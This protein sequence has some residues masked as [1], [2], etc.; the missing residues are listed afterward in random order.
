MLDKTLVSNQF[1]QLQDMIH[2][3][4]LEKKLEDKMSDLKNK[5]DNF[6]IKL[7]T[8]GSFSAG[9]SALLNH[10]IG[11]DLLV[12]EQTPETAI[13]TEL[14]F[15]PIEH[16]N[17]VDTNHF[18]K[19]VEKEQLKNANP[20]E[21]L[22][23][24]YA[25][26]NRY[27]APFTD[28][29]FVDMPGFNSN[30]EQHNKAILQYIG[31]GNAYLLVIDCEDGGIKASALE[32]IEEIRQYQHNLIIVLTKSDKKSP[33]QI[34]QIRQNVVN[35]A[36][37]LFDAEVPVITY[38]KFDDSARERL[39][40]AIRTLPIQSI[41]EQTTV[42]ILEELYSYVQMALQQSMKAATLDIHELEQEM[43]KRKKVKKELEEK[44]MSERTKLTNRMRV[45]VLPGIIE[46]VESALYANSTDLAKAAISGERAFS[47]RVNALLR[48]VLLENTKKF[49]E[50]SYEQFLR[51]IDFHTLLA[52]QTEEMVQGLQEKIRQVTELLTHANKKSDDLNKT[53]KAI[54]GITAITTTV[55]APW[56]EIVL[57][58][59]PE[60][61]KIFGVGGMD[62]QI[63]KVRVSI[64]NEVIPQIIEKLQPSIQESLLDIESQLME[65][66]EASIHLAISIE[67]EALKNVLEAIQQAD[68]NYQSQVSDFE[69][70]HS[71]I[72]QQLDLL[73]QT[74]G[75]LV[76]E[77][78]YSN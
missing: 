45:Q 34:E 72:E 9:K 75:G 7:L 25:L 39:A 56:L 28:F 43:T 50:E 46:A 42:P 6:S 20:S 78:E 70:K 47:S 67:E 11:E 54:M 74:A 24:Q 4:S 49:T 21:T 64:E 38:S 77:H 2:S 55:V 31:S 12:E 73:K 40:D 14:L 8:I 15:S 23:L 58:F 62:S 36:S 76:H 59:L 65:D 3:L 30:I 41:F 66:L 35:Q 52:N 60:L 61:L 19:S 37:Y 17:V 18:I 68:Q 27:L 71:F 13:A 48:P 69:Q 26:N 63:E 10:F 16:Y 1:Q 53:Y 29:T 5:M 57:L 44:L 32:F 22:H 33:S 51:E